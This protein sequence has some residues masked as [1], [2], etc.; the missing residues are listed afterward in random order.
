V[1]FVRQKK[2]KSGLISIQVI[3][4]S[5]GKYHVLKTIGSSRDPV[6]I[7]SLILNGKEWILQRQKALELDF[8]QRDKVFEQLFAGITAVKS[9]GASILLGQIFDSVGFNAIKDELFRKL[10]LS[11]LC[12]P[13]SKLKTTEYLRRYEGYVTDEDKIYR[14]LDKLNKTQ[15]RTVQ[16]ISYKHTLEVLG[17]H[18]SMV[19][20]DVTTLYFEANEE[21]ELRKTGYS[22]DGRHHNPQ[23]VLGLLV[24]KGGYPLAYEIFE[25]GKFEGHTMLPVINLFRRKYKVS[26]LI[27]VADAGL[28]SDKNMRVLR[29]NKYS[30]ILGARIKN[31]SDRIKSEI[32]KLTLSNGE[33]T[34]LQKDETN[35]L[36]ISY[37]TSRAV[38]DAMNRERGVRK[39]NKL[40]ENGKLTKK[41]VN[42]KGYNRFLKLDGDIKISLDEDKVEDDKKWDG[43]KGYVTNCSLSKEEIITNYGYLWQIE[44]AFRV[45]KSE[46]KIRPFYHRLKRRIEA[47]VCIAFVAYKLY[48]ELERLLKEK[49]SGLTPEKAIEIAKTIYEIEA[50]LPHSKQPLSKL[51]INTEEQ[52][53]LVKLF[54]F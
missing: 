8:E 4:K 24:S 32:L 48:K 13:V 22:K 10:V 43:L 25:G 14:Y 17:G 35:R 34:E 41:Q 5:M 53:H 37:S 49:N 19:F 11:R 42:N 20:Y 51:L 54:N 28:L 12:Y 16:C 15:K 21:D 29:E 7:Q 40:I 45:A 9:V 6:A 27:V 44:K 39:L 3:E 38:K 26:N 47:H 30:Y 50:V 23:I 1:V 31:E 18:I 46:I 52:R 2:N 33:I 36:I